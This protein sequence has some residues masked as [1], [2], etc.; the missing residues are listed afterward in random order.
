M[1]EK[2]Q[3]RSLAKLD[4]IKFA[5]NMLSEVDGARAYKLAFDNEAKTKSEQPIESR[6]NAFFRLIGLP[7]FVT[8]E[9][10]DKKNKAAKSGAGEFVLTPGYNEGEQIWQTIYNIRNSKDAKL[11]DPATG[12]ELPASTL[13]DTRREKV[14]KER[15]SKIGTETYNKAM[16][17]AMYRVEAPKL[18]VKRQIF[19]GYDYVKAVAP[20]A[21]SYIDVQPHNRELAAPFVPN[22]KN[23]EV[24]GQSLKKPFIET[25]ARIR[26]STSSGADQTQE[27]YMKALRDDLTAVSKTAFAS[28]DS[29]S[30]EKIPQLLPSE[31]SLL[32]SFIISQ[33]LASVDKLA[34]IWVKTQRKREKIVKGMEIALVP[35]TESAKQSSFGRQSNTSLNLQITPESELGRRRVKLQQRVAVSS[36][37]IGLIPTED[38]LGT[39]TSAQ[40]SAPKNVSSNAM[41]RPFLSLLRQDLDQEK[42]KL[43]EVDRKIQEESRRANQLR[44]EIEAL[45]GE[46]T[47]LSVIDVIFT[48]LALFLI[49]RKYLIGLLDNR[50]QDLM[51]LDKTLKEAS[52]AAGSATAAD[53][54]EEVAEKVRTLYVLLGA[55]IEYIYDKKKRSSINRKPKTSQQVIRTASAS[56]R[57]DDL[58]E[59]I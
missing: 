15:E 11:K 26:L 22:L 35:K 34:E 55:A 38:A 57:S 43:G 1:T 56:K 45:T 29:V 37:I 20:F 4:I 46:F 48:I 2:S 44:L 6:V 24:G 51:N 27:D 9:A 17:R 50:S 14:L 3:T 58:T 28:D 18:Y 33:M 10:L 16:I 42:K 31:A 25:V 40:F 36:A 39:T 12:N 54:V 23:T 5:R 49:D 52:T 30:T 19:S 21:T 7:M 59:E 47:G 8:I 41:T 32:E 53:S 13:V